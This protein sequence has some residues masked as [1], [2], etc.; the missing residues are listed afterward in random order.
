[1]VKKGGWVWVNVVDKWVI[2]VL[3]SEGSDQG[4]IKVGFGGFVKGDQTMIKGGS[5]SDQWWNGEWKM[6]QQWGHCDG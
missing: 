5:R 2:R 6:G 3:R 4:L 1:M